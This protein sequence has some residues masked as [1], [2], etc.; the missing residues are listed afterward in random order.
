[1]H[2]CVNESMSRRGAWV[3]EGKGKEFQADFTLSMEPNVGL[4]PITLRS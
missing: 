2:V 3:G 4:N 1:M